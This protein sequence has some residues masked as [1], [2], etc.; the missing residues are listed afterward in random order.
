MKVLLVR[1][2]EAVSETIDPDRSLSSRGQR[3]VEQ[4]AAFL[5]DADVQFDRI[6]HSG[7]TRARQTADQLGRYLIPGIKAEA[8]SG[9]NPDDSVKHFAEQVLEWTQNTI[10]VGHLPFLAILVAQLIKSGNA[11]HS[12]IRFTP[13]T[14]VCL[15]RSEDGLWSIIW[16]IDP[17]LLIELD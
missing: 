7:K 12:F 10:V 1:H 14:A 8:V 2:G 4:V 15:E 16:M 11:T 3:K 13:A 9:L 17:E 6:M 5:D